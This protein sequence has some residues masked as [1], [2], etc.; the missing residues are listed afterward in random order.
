MGVKNPR[1]YTD[2]F[3][4]RAVE[5]AEEIGLP[6]AGERLGISQN[7]IYHWRKKVKSTGK[8]SKT[9]T[10]SPSEAPEEE[11]RRLRKENADLKKANIILKQAAAFFSQDH[12][13]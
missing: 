9:D 6:A 3:K 7:N 1:K 2:D 10:R 13:K 11:L 12:L 8:V 4:R 5:L